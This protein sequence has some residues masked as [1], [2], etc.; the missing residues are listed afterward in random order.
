VSKH[1]V[2]TLTEAQ[3]DLF[4]QPN[5]AVAT[6][7]RT[8]GTLQAS[9]VWVDEEGGRPVFNTTTKRAKA[10]YLRK[11]H[12]VSLVVW[13]R[14][15]PYRYLEVEGTAEL[16]EE[17]AADHINSLS[18]KY[19]GHDF[20][21]RAD[22]VVVRVSPARIFDY[23]DGPPPN[24]RLKG[25]FAVTMSC[26]PNWDPSRQRREQDGWD[27]HASFMDGL[28]DE[29]FVVLGGPIG[30]GEQA[31]VIVEASAEQEVESCLGKDPWVRAGILEIGSIQPWTIWLDCRR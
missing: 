16:D 1:Q 2:L 10:R 23:L 25:T 18:H 3:R 17:G 28:V 15:D 8:D 30:D 4:R 14:N 13:D 26:G 19:R 31:M 12:R 24:P 6:T 7:M 5:F 21:S 11:D 20:P 22:R 27:E 29:G 9:V